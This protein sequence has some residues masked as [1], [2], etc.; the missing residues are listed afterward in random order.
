MVCGGEVGPSNDKDFLGGGVGC[1][2]DF[3]EEEVRSITRCWKFNLVGGE[4]RLYAGADSNATSA[5]E[6]GG[7]SRE[8]VAD[9]EGFEDFFI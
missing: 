9:V 5:T 2:S 6:R 1:N 3:D 4:G 7:I 8:G